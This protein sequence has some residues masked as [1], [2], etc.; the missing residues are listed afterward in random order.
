MPIAAHEGRRRGRPGGV[1]SN[2]ASRQPSPPPVD[3]VR[4][5]SRNA[6]AC[7]PPPARPGRGVLVKSVRLGSPPHDFPRNWTCTSRELTVH[8]SVDAPVG[9]IPRFLV[10][11]APAQRNFTHE[12][13]APHCLAKEIEIATVYIMT[14]GRGEGSFCS[15]QDADRDFPSFPIDTATISYLLTSIRIY[16]KKW[17]QQP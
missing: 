6:A 1:V 8:G 7:S 3:A 15:L 9:E 14:D 10:A 11:P 5:R 2:A 16:I 4:H 13:E 12:H 17:R